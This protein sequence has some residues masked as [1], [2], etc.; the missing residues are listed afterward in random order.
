MQRHAAHLKHQEE[1]A[2]RRSARRARH[3]KEDGEYTE[4]QLEVD[5]RRARL[6]SSEDDTKSKLRY[7]RARGPSRCGTPPHNAL[8]VHSALMA[9]ADASKRAEV[10]KEIDESVAALTKSL[11]E[12]DEF[13]KK[14]TAEHEALL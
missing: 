7:R 9:A 13:A 12:L 8:C 10:Q 11:A 6:R 1:R 3:R 14:L 4:K 5:R 2:L